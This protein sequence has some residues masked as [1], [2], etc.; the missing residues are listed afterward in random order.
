[1]MVSSSWAINFVC[2]NVNFRFKTSLGSIMEHSFSVKLSF[3]KKIIRQVDNWYIIPL[4]YYGLFRKEFFILNLKNGQRL[5]LRTDSTDFY[6]FINVWIVGEYSRTGF[7]IGENDNVV[8]VGSHIG[9]F[10]VYAAQFCRNGKIISYEPVE[11]N[12]RLLQENLE[13][14]KLKN[15]RAFNVAVA[16]KKGKIRIYHSEDQAASTIYGD[17]QRYTEVDAVP[18]KEVLES[19]HVERCDLLKLDCEGAEYEI[20]DSLADEYFA[21][22]SRICMEYHP[23][24]DNG[25]L[26]AELTYRLE[27]LG[28]KIATVPYAEGLGLLFAN[29]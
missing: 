18:L 13:L 4:V 26:L 2:W 8:D 6:T 10:S 7:E 21:R 17:G 23:I 25:K 22:I 12:F 11:E 5:K 14:N 29:K 28:Y 20:L 15:I 3:F 16:G 24:K 27:K 9:V 19:N 1:M